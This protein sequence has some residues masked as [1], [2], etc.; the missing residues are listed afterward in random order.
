V[1]TVSA[2]LVEI[3]SSFQTGVFTSQV[4]PDQKFAPAFSKKLAL[5]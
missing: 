5:N 2:L 3:I 4:Q 1:I